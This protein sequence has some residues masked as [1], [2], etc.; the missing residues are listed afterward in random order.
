MLDIAEYS[1]MSRYTEL[2]IE[3][4]ISEAVKI[5]AKLDPF[6]GGRVTAKRIET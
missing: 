1:N 5:A 6:T 4:L 2:G 3:I